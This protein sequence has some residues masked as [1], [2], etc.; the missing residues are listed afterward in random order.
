MKKNENKSGLRKKDITYVS[1][2]SKSFIADTAF[3]AMSAEQRGVYCTLIFYLY[4]NGGSIAFDPPT[5]GR[6]C[7]CDDFENIWEKIKSRFR[8]KRNKIFHSAVSKE[9]SRT[10]KLTQARSQSGLKGAQARWQPQSAAN[11]KS[12][13][14]NQSEVKVR[15]TTSN[16]G[17]SANQQSVKDKSSSQFANDES[18]KKFSKDLSNRIDS[19]E[20]LQ[21]KFNTYHKLC[22]DLKAQGSANQATLRNFVNWVSDMIKAEEFDGDKIWEVVLKICKESIGKSFRKPDCALSCKRRTRYCQRVAVSGKPRLGLMGSEK[23]LG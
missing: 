21:Q 23:S 7:N 17:T 19:G 16:P 11:A 14:A 2:D 13:E 1:L 3:Q 22:E 10:L 5:L 4:A 15:E 9:L 6:L 18:V 8:K 12:S 20:L